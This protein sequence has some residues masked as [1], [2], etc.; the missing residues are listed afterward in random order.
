MA[1]DRA[2]ERV[3]APE[4]VPPWQCRRIFGRAWRWP[5]RGWARGRRGLACSTAVGAL[6]GGATGGIGALTQ[7][8]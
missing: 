4:L 5:S 2:E 6:A 7:A 8:V 1:S 3:R